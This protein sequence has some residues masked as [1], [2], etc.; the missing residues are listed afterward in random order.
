ME[1]VKNNLDNCNFRNELIDIFTAGHL[2]SKL[3]LDSVKTIS[4]LSPIDGVELP[5]FEKYFKPPE[6][7]NVICIPLCDGRS[8]F[9]RLYR[10]Y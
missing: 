9:S 8:S 7:K 3:N 1:R 10:Q 6:K 4:Y 5:Y 2:L